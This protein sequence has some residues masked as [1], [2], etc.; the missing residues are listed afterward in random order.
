MSSE[1]FQVTS[2]PV[3]V[4]VSLTANR[5]FPAAP[6]VSITWQALAVGGTGPLEYQ[7]WRYKVSTS[8]WTMARAYGPVS[9]L[10]W[11]PSVA[12]GGRTCCVSVRWV[13]AWL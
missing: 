1:P 8:T 5:T 7:F 2:S 9:T 4:V 6:N 11:T 13:R 10:Q 12:D 3:P